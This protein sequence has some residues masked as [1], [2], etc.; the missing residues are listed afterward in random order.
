MAGVSGR[1]PAIPVAI[2]PAQV[3]AR[4]A[5]EERGAFEAATGLAEDD[6]LALPH[7]R[8]RGQDSDSRGRAVDCLSRRRERRRDQSP[9]RRA[10]RQG[11]RREDLSAARNVH[12][13]AG[14]QSRFSAPDRGSL[15]GTGLRCDHGQAAQSR[16]VLHQAR[17]RG[18]PDDR[19]DEPLQH[20][21]R[22]LLHGRESG[23]LRPRADARRREA[24]SGRRADRSSRGG[25]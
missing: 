10:R 4:A 7:L 5:H 16:H 13:H 12:R 8:A 23:R 24:A 3:G 17:A 2:L 15:P 21:V 6:R 1:Q 25:R 22:P 18:G 11:D 20:D 14:H 9:H 19:P